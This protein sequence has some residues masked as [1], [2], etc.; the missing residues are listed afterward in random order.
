M[1]AAIHTVAGRLTPAAPFDFAQTLRFAEDFTP[2]RGEQRVAENT[3]TKAIMVQGRP[4]GFHITN[5]GTVDAPAL[6]YTLYGAQPFTSDLVAASEDRLRFYLSLDDDLTHFYEIARDDP[7]MTPIVERR[8]GLH[9]IKFPTPFEN[10]AWAILTQRTPIPIARVVKDRLIQ[11][12]GG[13]VLVKGQ[14]KDETLWAFP[15]AQALAA[16]DPAELAD[17]I[18]NE[19]K[20]AYLAAASSA[21]ATIDERWLRSGDYD[22]VEAWL[23]AISGIGAWSAGF[24]L[25]RGLGRVERVTA[26]EPLLEAAA[27]AYGES[28]T[29]THFDE[30]TARYGDTSGYWAFYLRAGA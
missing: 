14:V 4:I 30:L 28:I 6:D 11:R 20:T 22:E 2:A 24:I 23:L 7:A 26:N 1:P 19:R 9:Q 10:A 27:R 17:L 25:I 12:Y 18:R 13:S 16:A 5:V 15:D 3:L 8:Y 29:P 21:F